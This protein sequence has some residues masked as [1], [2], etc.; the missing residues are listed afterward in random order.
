VNYIDYMSANVEFLER[1]G[2]GKLFT[3]LEP[4]S[5]ATGLLPSSTFSFGLAIW[6][7]SGSVHILEQT[8][9]IT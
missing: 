3:F 5:A 4:H 1:L 7:A 8:I 2:G 9:R 6:L